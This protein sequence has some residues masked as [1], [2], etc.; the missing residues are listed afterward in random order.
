MRSFSA[1]PDKSTFLILRITA[2]NFKGWMVWLVI[3]MWP[4]LTL[5]K[6]FLW[7]YL[8]KWVIRDYKFLICLVLHDITD[9]YGFA[10]NDNGEVLWICLVMHE[11]LSKRQQMDFSDFAR[12]LF[13][14]DFFHDITDLSG[15]AWNDNMDLSGY[16]RNVLLC[17][18]KTLGIYMLLHQSTMYAD[19][20]HNGLHSGPQITISGFVWFCRKAPH[21]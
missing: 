7:K 12:N 15:F 16:A 4:T 21:I 8:V 13:L 19:A 14:R 17:N 10:W 6:K 18:G 3:G 9:L 2:A 11:N 5:D 1:K 20:N